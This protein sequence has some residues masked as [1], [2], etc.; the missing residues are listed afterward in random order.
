MHTKRHTIA[1]ELI[2]DQPAGFTAL[3]FDETVEKAFGHTRIALSLPK[4]FIHVTVLIHRSPQIGLLALNQ[5]NHFLEMPGTDQTALAFFQFSSIIRA[6]LLTPFWC[7]F[8][9]DRDVGFCQELFDFTEAEPE[10][11]V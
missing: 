4:D 5:D 2:R 11:M 3:V 9:N 7:R 6:K 10:P 8:I 1:F